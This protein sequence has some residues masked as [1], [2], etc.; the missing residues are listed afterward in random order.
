MTETNYTGT[1][2]TPTQMAYGTNYNTYSAGQ[3]NM[4]PLARFLL[5]LFT[6]AAVAAPVTALITN[7]INKKREAK[8]V[9]QA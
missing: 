1:M 6:G 5:G 8:A 7:A 9:Q 4:S 3:S 2:G